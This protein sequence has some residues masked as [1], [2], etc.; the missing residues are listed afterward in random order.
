MAFNGAGIFVRLY[1][2]AND[3]A[4]AINITASR[5]DA[6]TDGIAAGLSNCITRDG[7]GKPVTA[8]DWNGQTLTNVANF[9]NTGNTTLGDAS[10]DILNVGAGGI[11]KDSIGNTSIGGS[12]KITGATSY[13]S[14]TSGV[15]FGL[16]SGSP[17]RVFVNSTGAANTKI[18]D[19]VT[20]GASYSARLINDAANAVQEWITVN[21]SGMTV[22]SIAFPQG[23]ITGVSFNGL[24][25]QTTPCVSVYDAGTQTRSSATFAKMNGFTIIGI[26]AG[27][28]FSSSTFTVPIFGVYEISGN[29]TIIGNGGQSTGSIKIYLNGATPA[30]SIGVAS[31]TSAG[32]GQ[33]AAMAF[34]GI[35]SLAAGTTVEIWSAKI[36]GAADAVFSDSHFTIRR[37]Q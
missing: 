19:E 30:A 20:D 14:A 23:A 11:I 21:R 29:S 35:A 1:N 34:T 27:S 3:A 4:N 26:D 24:L 28:N 15:S 2:W 12:L 37:V 36:A 31:S 9:A 22:S 32:L 33:P 7:Q 6:E 25:G 13:S 10:A 17:Q 18:W 16:A 8:I 5:M